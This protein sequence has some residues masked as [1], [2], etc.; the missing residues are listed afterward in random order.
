MRIIHHPDKNDSLDF[1]ENVLVP[2]L[3]PEGME[4]VGNID[5][6]K[7]MG[8]EWTLAIVVRKKI[9]YN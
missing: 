3:I 9:E 2:S 8:P 4:M 1:I 6:W 5:L 7:N